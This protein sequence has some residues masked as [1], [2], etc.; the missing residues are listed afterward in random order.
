VG[1]G[2]TLGNL[3][4]LD[5]AGAGFSMLDGSEYNADKAYKDSKLCN[6]LF[7]RELERR[8]QATGSPVQ[9]NAFGPGLITRTGGGMRRR[10]RDA[11]H[12]D[13]AGH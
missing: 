2:A 3:S 10:V 6:V 8:L 1:L 7:A 9:V 13:S 5:A 12:A 4:G 11:R